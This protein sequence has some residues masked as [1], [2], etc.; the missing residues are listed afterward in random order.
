MS[1]IEEGS[2]LTHIATGPSVSTPKKKNEFDM[3]IPGQTKNTFMISSITPS[4]NQSTLP[5]VPLTVT[6]KVQPQ[7]D[8]ASAQAQAQQRNEKNVQT[9][10]H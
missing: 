6:I 7:K 1:E 2:R 4:T 9:E 3:D 5:R 10:R 8:L